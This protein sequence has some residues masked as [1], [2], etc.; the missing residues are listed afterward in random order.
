MKYVFVL[1]KTQQTVM[2]LTWTKGWC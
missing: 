2:W 1:H